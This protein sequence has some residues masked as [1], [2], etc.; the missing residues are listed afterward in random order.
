M[1]RVLIAILLALITTTPLLAQSEAA[2]RKTIDNLEASIEQEERELAKLKKGKAS[3][4]KL[5]N[6]LARQIEKRNALIAARD[7]QIKQ[8][9]S[10]IATAERRV[11]ELSVD[12]AALE[13]SCAQMAREAYRN[14]RHSNTLAFIFSS[15]STLEFAHR[16]ASLRAATTMRRE[17]IANLTATRENVEQERKNLAAKRE[18]VAVAKRKLDRQ[19]AKMREERD[20]AKATI[21]QMTS[22]EKKV[23]ASMAEHEKRLNNAITE[24]RKIT[25]GNTSGGSF[26]TTTTG[27]KLPV[28]AGRVVRYNA[29]T[30]EIVGSKGASITSI[31]EGKVVRI[32]RNKIN[33]K[34]DVYIAH[35]EYISSYANLSEVCVKK[36]EQV[37][38]NQKIGTIASMVNP[39]TMDVEY[40]ILF[41]IHAPSPKVTMKASNLFK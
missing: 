41:A 6:S 5:V 16:I 12:L 2:L 29:N 26:S 39:A 18:E 11:G 19:R 35:G 30:A 36:D 7:K 21:R 28:A 27:L 4:Q 40:K 25:K 15:S 20:L 38:K 14:Y 17:Q 10:E 3:K 31:Y 1:R 34:Y 24:L 37:L 8:L 32:S 9:N 23:Q 13:N 22:K 33:N